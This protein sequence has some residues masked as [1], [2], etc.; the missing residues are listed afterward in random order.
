MS[1]YED[2]LMALRA[3]LVR[4]KL[5]G[6]VVPLTDEHMSE[7]VGAYAQ[8]LAWLTGF[9]GSAGS[10]VVLPEEAA[11]FVDGRYTLQVREQVDGTH[12]QY[13]S[14][15]QTSI[16]AWLKDH[17]VQGA[18]IGY[19][20]WLHTRAWVKQASEALAEKGADLVAV[21]TNPVD[22]IWPDR[23]A[24]S[25]ARLVVHDDRFAGRSAA[26]KRAEMADWL[27]TKKA[28]AAILSALDSIAWTFNIR[29]KDVD[30]T[31]VALAYAIVHADAT[32]DLYVAPEKMDETV[33]KH[34]GNGVRVHDR[35]A[36][37]DA[38]AEL[39]GK[40]VIA[41]PERA[42]A[43]IFEALDAGGAKILPLR[44]PAVLPKAVKNDTEIAGHKAAQARDG[45][46]LSRF[47]HWISVE[48]PKGGLTELSASDRL[49]AFRK[50]TGL[51][52]DLSFDTISGAG[53]NGAV[54]HYRVEESTNRPIET[55]TLYLVDS[56]GQ[57]RDGTTDVT[58]TI[59]VGTPTNEMKHRF[60]LVLKGHI[61]LARALFPKGTRGGQLD[62]L[63]RQYL[64]AEGLDYA[65]GTGHGVGSFL[66]VHE[67][68]QRIATF[69]GGDEPL[70]PGMILSNEPGYYKT[71][72]YGIRVENL[73]LVVERAIEGAEKEMLGFETLTFAP[74]DRALIVT[75]LLS[76]EER[77]WVDAYHAAVLTV[78]GPQLEDEALAWLKAACAPL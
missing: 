60:T 23:P 26:Q 71:G 32:A 52:E 43:A 68:P 14:V 48:A 15:P 67:G 39:G 53:P 78:V 41:D 45:A 11:I 57:Y 59:A 49:E 29:G 5:D 77:A 16:A 9:Q 55:G 2:R 72:E 64:W 27:T 37:A 34:L 22:A 18:R 20:P 46:A 58:R 75:E 21:D 31:P 69:G 35:S 28:D 56:G 4:Q 47:L 63:A 7:Y 70:V 33:A 17:A 30:R 44:D 40:T 19:D 76:P 54:V 38:L 24:P 36:F 1:S 74:I 62:V 42:V 13:E 8:R 12:W 3:Q 10:A 6:F 50:D 65:H 73:V 51:L 25:S 61:A 66:S